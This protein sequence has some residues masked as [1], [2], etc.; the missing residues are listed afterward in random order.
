MPLKARFILTISV[1]IVIVEIVSGL[2]DINM[3][4]KEQPIM[5]KKLL[6]VV[7]SRERK[8]V[9]KVPEMVS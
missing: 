9:S 2:I 3:H 6:E 7:K 5:V 1:V 4:Y 8:E